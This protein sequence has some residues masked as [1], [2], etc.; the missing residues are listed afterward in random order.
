MCFAIYFQP[1]RNDTSRPGLTLAVSSVFRSVIGQMEGFSF[2]SLLILLQ[3]VIYLIR[4]TMETPIETFFK[5]RVKS[6]AISNK[7]KKVK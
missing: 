4:T 3:V 6:T 7:V 1:V 5:R 2:M